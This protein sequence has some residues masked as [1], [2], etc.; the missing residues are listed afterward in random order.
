MRKDPRIVFCFEVRM[1]QIDYFVRQTG[2][3]RKNFRPP[4][5]HNYSPLPRMENPSDND[6]FPMHNWFSVVPRHII[7]HITSQSIIV[8]SNNTFVSANSNS[9]R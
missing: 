8:A 3:R 2:M 1:Q 6:T 7:Y 9:K 5:M 4:N